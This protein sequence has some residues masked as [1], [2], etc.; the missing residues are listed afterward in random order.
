RVV[1]RIVERR[2]L[3]PKVDSDETLRLLAEFLKDQELSAE[4]RA[5]AL[6][7]QAELL[8]RQGL[9]ERA[10]A[11]LVQTMPSLV[12]D[13]GPDRLSELYVLLGRAYWETGAL[14]D[15]ARQLEQAAGLLSETDVRRAE[16]EVLLA[17]VHEQTRQPPEEARA[18]AKQ[19]YE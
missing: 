9:T 19:R 18:E 17:R 5:W 16:A 11:K 3:T 12:A 7:K 14:A 1:K 13:A 2:L 8:L 15:A 10:I 6:A 4:D